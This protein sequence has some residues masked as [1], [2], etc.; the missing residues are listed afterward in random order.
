MV[1]MGHNSQKHVETRFE[2]GELDEL[3][4]MIMFKKMGGSGSHFQDN[5]PVD[6]GHALKQNVVR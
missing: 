5:R 1:I 6:C 4:M 2:K 3:E